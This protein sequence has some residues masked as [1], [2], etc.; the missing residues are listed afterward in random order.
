MPPLY[1]YSIIEENEREVKLS[2]MTSQCDHGA[3]LSG[4]LYFYQ[5]KKNPNRGGGGHSKRGHVFSLGS[6]TP[7]MTPLD[8][9]ARKEK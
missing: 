8:C 2:P 1:I 9:G 5:K 7:E 3:G 4:Y 6:E